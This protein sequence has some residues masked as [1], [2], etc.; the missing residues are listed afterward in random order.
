MLG[1]RVPADVC[2]DHEGMV[3]IRS[4]G[5]S[6]APAWRVLP[7]HRIPMRL[8]EQVPDA[9]GKGNLA[10]FRAGDGPFANGEVSA[11]LNLRL[12]SATH[13]LVEPRS[14]V[15]LDVFQTALAATRSEWVIDEE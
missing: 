13:G 1:V 4:G 15:H 11:T 12:D 3:K 14:V 8:R 9:R 10:C 2:P 6:V 5:M 7:P